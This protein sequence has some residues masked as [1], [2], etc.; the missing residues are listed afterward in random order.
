MKQLIPRTLLTSLC[1]CVALAS[2]ALAA[3]PQGRLEAVDA[4]GFVRGWAADPDTPNQA[5]TVHF[6]LDYPAG[7]GTFAGG[8]LATL[9][10]QG[11]TVP[12]DHGFVYAVPGGIPGRRVYAY[13]LDTSGQP[14]NPQ[15]QGSGMLIGAGSPPASSSPAPSAAGAPRGALESTSG[16]FATGWAADPDTPGQAVTVHFYADGPAGQGRYVGEAS[17][18]LPSGSA[19]AAGFA[20]SHG[21]RFP[22]PGGVGRLYAY[23]LNTSGQPPNPQ[24]GMASVSGGSAAPSPGAPA[25][26]GAPRGALESTANGV[27]SGWAA[28]P[29]TLGQAVTVHFYADGPAGQGRFVG[30][31]SADLQSASANSAGYA[32]SHGYRFVVPAGA[33][34]IYVY[35]LN[36][37][38]QP[39]NPQIGSA[40]VTP[41]A[42]APPVAP[43]GPVALD[44]GREIFSPSGQ[45]EASIHG[46]G[47]IYAPSV[48]Y[49]GGQYM[50]WYGGFGKDGH[51]RI[52]LAVSADG[53]TGWQKRGVVIEN[54]NASGGTVNHVNDPSVLEVNGILYMYYTEAG[55]GFN[56][57]VA[58]ATS[59][60]GVSW[61]LQGIVLRPTP[62][63]PGSPV[64]DDRLV[65]RPSVIYENG[66]F[67]MAFDG[68]TYN[69][70]VVSPPTN[71]QWSRHVGM[72][73]ATDAMTFSK[74]MDGSVPRQILSNAGA[75]DFAV[76][77]NKYVML[78]ESRDGVHYALGTSPSSPFDY[79]GL[80]V[81]TSGGPFD[82]HGHITPHWLVPPTG[83]PSRI[84]MGGARLADW[85]GQTMGVIELSQGT[86]N[87]LR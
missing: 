17:A 21:Y 71:P 4:F 53:I 45:T 65:G 83:G 10:A 43:A 38:G 27:V 73:A 33:S 52:H 13:A 74:Y 40:G 25:T 55:Q 62:R 30:Q 70:Q 69:D 64:W 14:P 87:L 82:L 6:Y 5:V 1:A 58:L 11:S 77:G 24:I 81:G 22:I 51:D 79:R 56:D 19:G 75:V 66:V 76:V 7:Q 49:H 18:Y 46:R 2:P 20:G 15:I 44:Q 48:L 3:P 42:G 41:A 23:A 12:G 57:T 39:P 47:N 8:T 35:A 59:N 36:T 31:A 60:D 54:R 67:F 72:A 16:G 63:T 80:L 32:G 68:T 78:I 86:V 50:M 28:D 61:A 29:D 84:Y 85:T 34:Q 37:S 26:G 9:S